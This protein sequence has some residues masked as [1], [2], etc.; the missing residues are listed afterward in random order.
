VREYLLC[1]FAAAAV[2]YLVT[3]L[4]RAAALRFGAMAEVRD[5]DVHDVPIPRWGGIAM[6][7]GL[8]A[9]LVL[10]EQLPLLSN[11]FADSS[12]IRG[13]LQACV[14]IVVLGMVDDRWGLDAATKLAGQILAAG[15]MALQGISLVWLPIG[16]VLV[17]DSVASVALTVFVVV[18]TIN[19]VNFVD[20]LDGLAAGIVGI[21]AVAFFAYSYVLSVSKGFD[22]ATLATLISALLVG[23]CVGFLPHNF[24]PARVFMGDTGSM[25]IGLLLAASTITLT[26]QVDPI[27]VNTQN[28]VPALLPLVLPV[29]VVAV[30]LVD[31]LLAVVRRT[32]AGRSPFAPDKEHLH[33]RLLEMGHSQRRAAAIM[34]SWSAAIAFSVLAYSFVTGLAYLGVVVLMALAAV[35]VT[36]NIPSLRVRR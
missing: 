25:L 26:G 19:A 27:A 29:A 1:L 14:V 35:L 33:H 2:T 34:Y 8:C 7:A 20:G 18:L 21:A 6:L 24:Y 22:R 13:L 15:L 28:L 17:L 12:T 30:P 31:L 16:G 5:R 11:V 4:A 23:V 3:N 36:V 10:A 9:G 32:R